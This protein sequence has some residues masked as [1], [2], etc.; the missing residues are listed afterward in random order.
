VS[1]RSPQAPIHAPQ[2]NIP[3]CSHDRQFAP[4]RESAF[5]ILGGM[6]TATEA[7]KMRLAEA[8]LRLAREALR[9]VPTDLGAAENFG[10]ALFECPDSSED[11]ARL[12]QQ[13]CP[14]DE[15]PE[16]ARVMAD[17]SRA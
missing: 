2:G 17:F 6:T 8:S 15:W 4:C 14:A 7:Q 13:L 1:F 9:G 3:Q 16:I 5:V 10:N 12:V 11:V